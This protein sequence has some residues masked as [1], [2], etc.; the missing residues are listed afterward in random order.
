[1]NELEK[2]KVDV[3]HGKLEELL[4]IFQTSL[5]TIFFRYGLVRHQL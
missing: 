3:A 2:E 1:M 4:I 5:D